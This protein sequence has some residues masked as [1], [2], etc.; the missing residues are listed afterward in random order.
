MSRLILLRLAQALA[1]AGLAGVLLTLI[2]PLLPGD[3]AILILGPRASAA[4]AARLRTEMGLDQ[5]LWRQAA[6]FLL[7]ALR[8]DLGRDFWRGLPVTGLVGAALPHT[9]LLATAGMGL[10]AGI[11]IPVGAICA[12]R[13][14]GRLDRVVQLAAVASFTLPSYV[15]GLLLL[16]V[17][18]VRLGWLPAIG[19]GQGEGAWELLRHLLLPAVTLAIGWSG[20]LARLVRDAVLGVLGSDHI[21]A[22]RAYGVPPRRLLLRHALRP[23]LAPVVAIL[24]VG[25]GS[26]LGGAVFIE[27]IFNR[28]GLGRLIFDAIG[29]RNFPVLRGAVFVAA[30][31]YVLC[32]L[33]AELALAALDPRQRA[34]EVD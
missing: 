10:A 23:A 21:R 24:G 4:L 27:V 14:G 1:V 26:L 33:A 9:L 11:G 2:A 29:D 13:S 16:L 5:P 32:N 12:W 19:A 18:A 8:G 6:G 7:G 34:A 28:P 3:P 15:V 20:Y 22:A 17:F 25:L 30:L 31:L